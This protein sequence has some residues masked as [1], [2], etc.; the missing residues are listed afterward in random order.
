MDGVL[1]NGYVGWI[2]FGVACFSSWTE[3]AKR[4]GFNKKLPLRSQQEQIEELDLLFQ[5][6]ITGVWQLVH[7][8]K[9]TIENRWRDSFH[10]III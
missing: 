5:L 10:N 2:P 8:Q 6:D 7:L 1:I 3:A 4:Q 9:L